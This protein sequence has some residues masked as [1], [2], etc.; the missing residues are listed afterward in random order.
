MQKVSQEIDHAN[1]PV[2]DVFGWEEYHRTHDL[3]DQILRKIQQW[4][5]DELTFVGSG[6]LALIA[7]CKYLATENSLIHR[8]WWFELIV[9]IVLGI[10]LLIY[11]ILAILR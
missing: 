2:Q 7:F 10:E 11:A 1:P 5:I 4:I 9:L 3:F 8:I 6:I